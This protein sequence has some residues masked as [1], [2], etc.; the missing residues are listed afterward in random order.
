MSFHKTKIALFIQKILTTVVVILLTLVTIESICYFFVAQGKTFSDYQSPA[1]PPPKSPRGK[2]E[3]E[4]HSLNKDTRH[5]LNLEEPKDRHASYPIDYIDSNSKKITLP[6][7]NFSQQVVKHHSNP[8]K[9][10]IYDILVSTDKFGRRIN[11]PDIK[12]DRHS[13]IFIF[14]GSFAFGE[15][16]NDYETLPA[17]LERR[18]PMFNVYNLGFSGYTVTDIL[19]R[20]RNYHFLDEIPQK[21]G[22]GIYL[23]TDNHIKRALGFMSVI[24]D[25]GH[26]T[27]A[28]ED[29]GSYEFTYVGPHPIA[30]PIRTYLLRFLFSTNFARFFQIDYPLSLRDQHY[31]TFARMIKALELEYKSRTLKANPFIFVFYP[32]YL[33]PVD[34]EKLKYYLNKHKI[35]FIDY[36]DLEMGERIVEKAGVDYDGHPTAKAYEHLAEMLQADLAPYIQKK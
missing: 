8:Q 20:I 23:F 19:A 3:F 11:N 24:G 9:P 33:K 36:T 32:E 12:R 30:F 28:F 1:P 18:L 5:Q 6:K 15:A 21:N 27:S 2:Y 16:V 34:G 35:H 26:R 17:Q 10:F 25:W 13:H 31:D 4:I 7:A 22:L 29:H 14:G